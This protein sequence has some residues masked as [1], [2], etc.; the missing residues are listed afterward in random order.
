MRWQTLWLDGDRWELPLERVLSTQLPALRA[1]RLLV[2]DARASTVLQ[3]LSEGFLPNLRTLSLVG[4]IDVSLGVQIAAF[5]NLKSLK[6]LSSIGT[7]SYT[8]LVEMMK[9]NPDLDCLHLKISQTSD[10]PN[11]SNEQFLN[12]LCMEHLSSLALC[13]PGFPVNELLRGLHLPLCHEIDVTVQS[14]PFW[15]VGVAAGTAI[16]SPFGVR[17]LECLSRLLLAKISYHGGA[18]HLSQGFILG[19]N[20]RLSLAYSGHHEPLEFL[21][22]IVKAANIP[23]ISFNSLQPNLDETQATLLAHI[24]NIN[25]ISIYPVDNALLW[26]CLL[27]GFSSPS[28]KVELIALKVYYDSGSETPDLV[29][30][31]FFDSIDLEA[32][33]AGGIIANRITFV[34]TKR[35]SGRPSIEVSPEFSE[36]QKNI[37]RFFGCTVLFETM[38]IMA[39]L[40]VNH[41]IAG[42]GQH[43]SMEDID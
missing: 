38:S 12:H 28:K 26:G 25:C 17:L 40:I 41:G 2:D 39:P 31:R 18:W 7:P 15:A 19:D 29:L 37:E 21:A 33:T 10:K 11:P 23:R 3:R 35:W 22:S 36:L 1:L 16:T 20:C 32:D 6:I 13:M 4:T 43:T 34:N 5:R 27:S 8:E 9:L 14:P 30:R 24:P 42:I